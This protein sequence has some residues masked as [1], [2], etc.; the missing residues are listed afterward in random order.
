MASKVDKIVARLQQKI[1]DGDYYEAQQQA[2]VAASRYIKTKNW[3]AAIDTLFNVAQSLLKA[4]QGGSGGDLCIMLVDVYKQA[5]LA[6]DSASKG[7]LLTCLR[8]FDG[9]E[10]T[11]KKWSSKLGEYPAG[12]PELHHVAGSIYAE[13]HDTYEAE[14]HLLLGTRDSPQ[15]LFNMEYAWYK[16]GDAHL[17]PHFAGRAVLAYLLVGNVRAANTCYRL[18]VGAL[19]DDNPRLGVQDVSSASAHVRVFPSLPLLNFLGLLLLAIQRAAPE[20]YKGLVSKYATHINETDAWAEPL[21]MIAEMYF[22]IAKPRQTNPLMDMMSGL[23]GGGGP[24][25][26]QPPRRQGIRG[27]DV[28][29]AEGLD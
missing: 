13:E 22:G 16:E 18:F 8:L 25:P 27:S 9:E 14:R 29:V 7:R 4:S 24:Q 26:R 20:V 21:E 11:R 6:P 5:E 1:A 2:R 12:D 3:D 17:A 10:P 28:P 15:L 23:F 19:A